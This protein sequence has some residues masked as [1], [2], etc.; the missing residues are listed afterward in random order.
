MI[1]SPSP[2][3]FIN[4]GLEETN[5]GEDN[6]NKYSTF[7][8]EK[9]PLKALKP[10]INKDF[11]KLTTCRLR[12]KGETN[13]RMSL[14]EIYFLTYKMQGLDCITSNFPSIIYILGV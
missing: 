13:S 10:Y 1:F 7:Q 6:H 2:E 9:K 5:W 3:T 12:S 11:I 14:L 8:E 4:I